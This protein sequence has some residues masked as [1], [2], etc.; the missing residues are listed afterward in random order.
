LASILSFHQIIETSLEEA[1]RK[2]ADN[3]TIFGADMN[4]IQDSPAWRDLQGFFQSPRN[5]IFG[6]YIDWFNPFTNKIAGNCNFY[7]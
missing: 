1:F 4:D 6:I 5:L 3:P 7:V 2:H